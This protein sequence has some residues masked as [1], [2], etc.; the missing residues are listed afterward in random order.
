MVELGAKV[1]ELV[2]RDSWVAAY[3]WWT[4][5][6]M[7]IIA[8]PERGRRC[9]DEGIQSAR[10][11]GVPEL[12]HIFAAAALMEL[13]GDPERD[14][15]LRGTQMIEELLST[16]AE[17]APGIAFNVLAAAAALGNQKASE[18][19]L[20]QIPS[21]SPVQRFL[22]E[23]VGA[24]I[25][26]N[27]GRLEAAGRHLQAATAVG[28]EHAV[29]LCEASCLIGFSALAASAGDY[30]RASRN[31]ASVTGSG[32]FQARFTVDVLVYRM[33]ARALHGALDPETA[34]RC[35]AEGAAMS[36]SEALDA[37]LA[38]LENAVHGSLA[39]SA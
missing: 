9:I 13:T 21:T 31:L 6:A 19:L 3:A 24:L 38:R 26:R 36:V 22:H 37:E 2:P 16:I 39:S 34:A 4:Q 32:V 35:R 20:S 29:G 15:A 11:A 23:L 7:W 10:A 5:A 18:R 27:E 17:H 8:D 1:L 30:E 25:A 28:R 12:E 33:T 14:A